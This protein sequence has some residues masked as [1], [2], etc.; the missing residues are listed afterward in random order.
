MKTEQRNLH[1]R[2]I[3]LLET[4][5]IVR[6][7]NEEDET[8]ARA[9]RDSLPQIAQAV[10]AIAG[11]LNQGGRLFY[12]GAGTS[13]RLGVLDAVEC[14]PTFGVS[15]ELVQGILAGGYEAC[16]RATE[17][18][19][20]DPQQGKLDLEERGLAFRD[21]VV[22]IAASGRTPYTR[23]ALAYAR[24][25]KAL[26][27]GISCNRETPISGEVDIAIE[28]DA[29]PE[30]I[31]GSTRLKAGSAQ[32][33]ILNMISTATMVR[34]GHVYSNLMVNLHVSNQKL[35]ERAVRMISEVVP[36]TLDQ[37]R[38]ALQETGN[39]KSAIVM[40]KLGITADHA[41][42]LIRDSPNIRK[43]LQEE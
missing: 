31:A 17:V 7:M 5:E 12:V 4:I 36:A 6:L 39:V 16:Y 10:D 15:P 28:V 33:M 22:G 20:D 43:I 9:V 14:P 40:L 2:D 34:L 21:A 3:D 19:E 38:Q 37:A 26:T 27:V 30:V 25:V 24:S 35:S 1:S 18:S 32:K 8:V 42:Q 13:G 11:R 41:S 23:G 29:G